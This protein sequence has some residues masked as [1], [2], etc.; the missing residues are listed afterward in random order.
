MEFVKILDE[1][2]ELHNDENYLTN[3]YLYVLER[4]KECMQCNRLDVVN[5]ILI[6][7]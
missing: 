2:T 7:K 5:N 1:L 6:F 3:D 4:L